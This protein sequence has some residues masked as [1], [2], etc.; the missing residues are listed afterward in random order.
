[1]MLIQRVAGVVFILI[2]LGCFV[3]APVVTP[4]CERHYE[5]VECDIS[6]KAVALVPIQHLAIRDLKDVRLDPEQVTAR[7]SHGSSDSVVTQ[8][9]MVLVGDDGEHRSHYLMSEDTRALAP[10]LDAI[11]WR[12]SPRFMPDAPMHRPSRSPC[13]PC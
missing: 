6:M 13:G 3:A 8:W 5:R 1:M 7:Y 11:Q 12:W 10:I 9:A 4:R 2:G